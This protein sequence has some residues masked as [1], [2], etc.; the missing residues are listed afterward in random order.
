MQQTEEPES[1]WV[2]K[3]HEYGGEQPACSMAPFEVN[4]SH[5]PQLGQ[6]GG[7]KPKRHL[8]LHCK[9]RGRAGD[10]DPLE[11]FLEADKGTGRKDRK[12]RE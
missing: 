2:P 9:P 8:A 7:K 11:T 3:G 4:I 10:S 5:S 6:E 12:G 1:V